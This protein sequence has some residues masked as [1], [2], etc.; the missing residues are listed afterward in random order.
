M[1][2]TRREL[3]TAAP[4]LAQMR[5]ETAAAFSS[6]FSLTS[7]ATTRAELEAMLPSLQPVA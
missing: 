4:S 7:V 6:V 1:T 2:S 3:G 5:Q